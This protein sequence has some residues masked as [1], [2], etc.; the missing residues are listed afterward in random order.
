MTTQ[1][2][3]TPILYGKEAERVLREAKTMPSEK[4]KENGRKLLELFKSVVK[5]E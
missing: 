5:G 2:M 4:S 1:I 3:A